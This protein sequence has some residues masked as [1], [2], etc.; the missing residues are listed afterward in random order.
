MSN[1]KFFSEI[2]L[3]GSIILNVLG[4]LLLKM[5]A[6]N[7]TDKVID[8]YLNRYVIFGLFLYALSALLYIKALQYIKV[9]V[10]FPSQSIAYIFVALYAVFYFDERLSTLQMFGFVT[11]FCGVILL[12]LDNVRL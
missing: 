11:I 2:L 6:A 9:S 7:M 10:A 12:W 3:A 8:F 1:F 5:N 4:Q